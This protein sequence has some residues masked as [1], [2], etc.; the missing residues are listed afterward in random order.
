MFKELSQNI[1]DAISKA[2]QNLRH[3]NEKME[4][5]EKY[6]EAYKEDKRKISIKIKHYKNLKQ[7]I[8]QTEQNIDNDIK[9]K[10]N[11]EMT[12]TNSRFTNMS[13]ESDKK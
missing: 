12:E 5:Y 2:E 9:N 10:N 3:I 6:T 7:Q 1:N 4:E 13:I 8:E 11:E